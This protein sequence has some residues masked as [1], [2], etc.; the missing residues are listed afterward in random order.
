[1]N[2]ISKPAFTRTRN[3]NIELLRIT[4]MLLVLVVHADFFSL[5]EPKANDIIE[6]PVLSFV[7]FFVESC[8]IVCVNAFVLIS[9]W[10]SIKPKVE[11]FCNFFFQVV[12]FSVLL[13]F[14]F[15]S[16]YKSPGEWITIVLGFQYWFVRAYIILYLLSP[17]LNSFVNT[18]KR[19]QLLLFIL[20]FYLVQTIYGW[21]L[22][23]AAWFD[24]GYSPLSFFGLY[25]IGRY[26]RI[27][28]PFRYKSLTWG[29]ILL[30]VGM[31]N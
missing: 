4:A 31:F 17:V 7:R 20:L 23:K 3:S 2:N 22:G 10:F 18:A 24:K 12:F 1:M 14:P 28:K 9:G 16:Y 30:Y 19:K 27:Y 29:G 6:D 13:Y 21:Y 15:G 26:L 11:R 5:S 25:L 8:S